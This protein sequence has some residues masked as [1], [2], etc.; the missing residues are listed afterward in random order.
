MRRQRPKLLTQRSIQSSSLPEIPR[1]APVHRDLAEN[2]P[3]LAVQLQYE[4]CL[5]QLGQQLNDQV[6]ALLETA[7]PL[8]QANDALVESAILQ[9]LANQVSQGLGDAQVA[10][11]QPSKPPTAVL[12]SLATD[13]TAQV[14]QHLD[15]AFTVRYV[16]SHGSLAWRGTI[17][18]NQF[19]E[20]GQS[21][22]LRELQA[23]QI[24]QPA[25]TREISDH[26]ELRGWLLIEKASHPACCQPCELLES[27]L[28]SETAQFI[29]RAIQ[30]SLIVL[31]Q[32][33]RLAS[34]KR[35]Q[36]ILLMRIQELEQ[37]NQRKSEFLA[38]TSHEIR[39]PL[40]SI[41]GFTHLLREQG[42]SPT[43][44][45]HQEYLSIIL[46]SGQH[47]LA[48]IND[49]LDL[50]KIEANQLDL[51]WETIDVQNLCQ[52]ALLLVREK[53]NDKGLTI[54]VEITSDAQ[55][56]IADS[57]RLKQMLFNL[58][59]NAIKFTLQGKI[60]L[61]V[62]VT[63]GFMQFTVWDT[64][65]GIAPEQQKLLFRPY[66]QIA[67]PA[68]GREQGTGLGLALTQKLAELHGG[69]VEV[70]S[71]L[72]QGSRFTIFLPLQPPNSRLAPCNSAANPATIYS[73]H[74]ASINWNPHSS[75][76][77]IQDEFSPVPAVEEGV[78]SDRRADQPIAPET[79]IDPPLAAYRPNHVL[80][81]EDNPLNAK[82]ILTYL[83]KLGYELTWV[84]EGQEM[85]QA[86]ERSL[87]ALILMDVHLPGSDG[88]TLT[89]QLRQDQRYQEI[90]VIAQT[91]MAMS[92]DR[93]I[94][95]AAG[96]TDYIAK[97][98]D[99]TSLSKLV[100]QY[101]YEA[102]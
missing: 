23:R 6:T 37:I 20:L 29:D 2:S 68:A 32:I 42:Y 34:Q 27:S 55:I 96:A 60:G 12:T 16:A 77:C 47:L 63:A 87:P 26:S 13:G 54:R 36:Q 11:L 93:E 57:L 74:P 53:A 86:L 15:G 51:Q 33:Q 76:G 52:T 98:L 3:Q 73:S 72:N 7:S 48:L 28:N 46:A 56:L 78:G 24:E 44:L 1:I 5:N 9:I 101:T 31:R 102:S 91:A 100:A 85:W 38:N 82:L 88:L 58:L 8:D 10:I 35:Q 14:D 21:L 41:L 94:C 84:K 59:S 17:N 40:S 70:V 43:S 50:S 66:S 99:L 83:S 62:S 80:L 81:V 25:S 75:V 4:R 67:N 89:Q 65:V 22:T 30:Q 45:R 69:R 97:P 19:L 92:G 79:A 90:P 61:E 95:L 71:E 18:Q 39:T 64:G 49:I